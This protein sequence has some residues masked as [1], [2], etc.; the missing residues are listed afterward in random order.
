MLYSVY[1]YPN[2]VLPAFGGIF[3]DKI[4]IR[5][6]LLLFTTI[7]TLGQFVCAAGVYYKSYALMLAGRVIFGLGGESMSVAQSAIVSVWFK[8]KELAFALGVNLSISRLGSVVN[9]ATVP[10]MTNDES[11][12]FAYLVGGMICVFSLGN[13]VGLVSLDKWAEK[14]NPNAEKAALTD[15]DKFKF[16]DLKK[17][18]LAFWLLTGSCVVTYMSVFPYLQIVSDVLK[19]KYNFDGIEAGRLFGIPYIISAS[20]SPFLGLLIDKVGKRAIIITFSSVVLSVAY[21]ISMNLKPCD[22]CYSEVYSLVL[23][24]CGYSI[25]A[26]A[27]WGSIPYVV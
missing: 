26:A 5:P 4:G 12:T 27:I 20:T 13:A 23:V 3:L 16:S 25:Y 1:S 19:T 14:K 11:M 6:G 24:G 22:R 17:F 10:A 9:G 8:G 7:L 18:R 2:M 15:E 21:F